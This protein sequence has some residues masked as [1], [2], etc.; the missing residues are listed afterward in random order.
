MNRPTWDESFLEIA[1]A[2]ARRSPDPHVQHGCVIIDDRQRILSTGYN[3]FPSGLDHSII[4]PERDLAYL[5]FV[6]D[7]QNA[8]VHLNGPAIGGTAYL[9]GQPCIA[10]FRMLAQVGIKR[11]VRGDRMSERRRRC[12]VARNEAIACSTIANHL[13]IEFVTFRDFF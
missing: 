10:C 3:G 12:P 2:V 7:A 13:A 9:T 1:Q 4:P 11:I 6:H 5:Y 8:I